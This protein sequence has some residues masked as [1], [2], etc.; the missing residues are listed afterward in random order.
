MP[1][2]V[3][4]GTNHEGFRRAHFQN[5]GLETYINSVWELPITTFKNKAVVISGKKEAGNEG[6]KNL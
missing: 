2:S 1:A 4:N 5:E 6:V 3:M